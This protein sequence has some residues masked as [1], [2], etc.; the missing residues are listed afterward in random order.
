MAMQDHFK[1]GLTSFDISL[2]TVNEMFLIFDDF[3]DVK[4][5]KSEYL[6]LKEFAK[7]NLLVLARDIVLSSNP[8]PN[9][10]NNLQV[11]NTNTFFF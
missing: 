3:S 10:I 6:I 8:V 11:V 7:N 4:L 9:F 5:M 2:E 1:K